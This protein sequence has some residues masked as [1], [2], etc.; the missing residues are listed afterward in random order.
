MKLQAV[1]FAIILTA[2]TAENS[3]AHSA[4]YHAKVI[5]EEVS[6]SV[7]PVYV[8]SQKNRRLSA[9]GS[10]VALSSST[11]V[12]NCH[13]LQPG[14]YFMIAEGEKQYPVE[15]LRGDQFRDVCLLTVKGLKLKR[16]QIRPSQHVSVGEPVYAVGNPKGSL[17][18]ITTG[19]IS[20]KLP[21]EGG[22]WLQTDAMINFGSSGGGLFDD[23][24]QL[25]GITTALK[26]HFG[27]AIPTEW[28]VAELRS[29]EKVKS[30]SD[31]FADDAKPMIKKLAETQSAS[32]YEYLHGNCFA[33]VTG[34]NWLG[35]NRGSLFWSSAE[36][37][38]VILFPNTTR[39]NEILT[40]VEHIL[41][42]GPVRQDQMRLAKSLLTLENKNLPLYLLH[43][44]KGFYPMLI[45]EVSDNFIDRLSK[46]SNIHALFKDRF[47]IEGNVSYSLET[48]KPFLDGNRTRCQ[49]MPTAS[50]S[51]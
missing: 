34:K 21:V 8:V 13:V 14:S 41:K 29:Q 4:R 2:F 10:S 22:M 7:Y 44:K 35:Q 16:A 50:K 32:L 31:F 17:K 42:N 9:V 38:I 12:T 45:G 33:L 15:L 36:P 25:I 3:Q 51:S 11:L 37:S 49:A 18:S 24:G 46:D 47:L 20:N 23:N 28:V 19:I 30:A 48:L 26:G 39:V 43:E 6:P 5:Y 40:I 27:Y 1:F